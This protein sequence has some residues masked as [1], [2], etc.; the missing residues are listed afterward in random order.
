MEMPTQGPQFP[1]FKE[2][3]GVGV[4]KNM[5]AFPHLCPYPVIMEAFQAVGKGVKATGHP[6]KG[7]WESCCS[8]CFFS[9]FEAT[10]PAKLTLHKCGTHIPPKSS[11]TPVRKQQWEDTGTESAGTCSVTKVL[12]SQA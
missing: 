12:V 5:W 6:Q 10:K 1:V 4:G 11:Q 7:C 2:P 9:F 3:V 8:F